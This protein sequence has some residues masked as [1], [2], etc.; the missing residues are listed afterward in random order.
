MPEIIIVPALFATIAFVVW[1]IASNWQRNRHLREMTAFHAR[2]IDRM[3]SIKDFND[4]LQTPGG[5]QFMNAITA[6]K[7]PTGP[8]ERILRAVQT[9]IVLS[10]VGGGSLLLSEMFQYEASDLFTVAG[11]ILLSLGIGFLVAAGAAYDLSKRLGVLPANLGVDQ[12][13]STR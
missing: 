3:G 1:T 9:G 12:H 11:V 6:D 8:R 4:F 7:G 2:I 13:V 5:M 10:S